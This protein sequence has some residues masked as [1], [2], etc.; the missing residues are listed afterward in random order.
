RPGLA[1]PLLLLE[2]S[3]KSVDGGICPGLAAPLLLLEPGAFWPPPHHG[4]GLAAPL[5]LLEPTFCN[6]LLQKVFLLNAVGENCGNP[7]KTR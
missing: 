1:A 3:R 2:Q 7:A 4:P 6:A 5:L